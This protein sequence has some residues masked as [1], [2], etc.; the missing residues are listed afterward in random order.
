[1][2]GRE[3]STRKLACSVD[4]LLQQQSLRAGQINP[5]KV[6][7]MSQGE[8]LKTANDVV[9]EFN[10]MR[11]QL[12]NMDLKVDEGRQ[13]TSKLPETKWQKALQSSKMPKNQSVHSKP[14][15]PT[16][17]LSD[18][19]SEACAQKQQGIAFEIPVNDS[20]GPKRCKKTPAIASLQRKELKQDNQ[21]MVA[22]KV[23]EKHRKATER[24]QV[25]VH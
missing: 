15:T 16:K 21:E 7:K 19:S 2:H 5:N 17:P 20:G 14:S 13:Q 9:K 10:E 23:E 12:L 24:R 1:M 25:C 22:L 3:E 4:L 11:C 18:V 8:I 6:S